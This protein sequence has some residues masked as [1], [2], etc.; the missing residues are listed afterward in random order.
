MYIM[1]ME[2]KKLLNLLLLR[3]LLQSKIIAR[4]LELL[5]FQQ[6][7]IDHGWIMMMVKMCCLHLYIFLIMSQRVL[8]AMSHQIHVT[9][10]EFF[11]Q[12]QAAF[13]RTPLKMMKI[14]PAEFLTFQSDSE[15]LHLQIG[16][17][18][19][20]KKCFQGLLSLN[21]T[22]SFAQLDLMLINLIQFT[23]KL[24]QILMSSITSG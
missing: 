2:H 23:K 1:E 10:K 6:N 19:L 17:R 16:D 11:T 22:L 20:Q 24:I 12:E 15:I 9:I 8:T 13:M 21:Q 18:S 14:I 3:K 7:S 5:R 4:H